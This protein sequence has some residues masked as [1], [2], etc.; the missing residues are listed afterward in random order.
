MAWKEPLPLGVGLTLMRLMSPPGLLAGLPL[1]K[2]E[3]REP[4]SPGVL[5]EG[6]APPALRA[7]EPEAPPW[8]S[9]GPAPAA[10]PTGLMGAKA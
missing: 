4:P 8:A 2:S 10:G 6:L 7:A 1:E 3:S 5:P 9:P